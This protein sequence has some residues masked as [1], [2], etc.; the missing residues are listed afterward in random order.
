MEYTSTERKVLKKSIESIID[1]MIV[2]FKMD[3]VKGEYNK[4][5]KLNGILIALDTS[6]PEDVFEIDISIE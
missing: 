1:Y 4:D 3:G 2:N 6:D 5:D